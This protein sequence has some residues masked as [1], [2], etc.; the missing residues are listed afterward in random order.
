MDLGIGCDTAIITDWE[1]G[2]RLPMIFYTEKIAEFLEY[3][4]FPRAPP[5]P[6]A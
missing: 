3:D 4:S 2:H 5:S 6:S 1:N